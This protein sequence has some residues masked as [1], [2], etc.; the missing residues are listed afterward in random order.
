MKILI[1][2]LIFFINNNSFANYQ[3]PKDF[4]FGV[5]NAPGQ[6][7]DQL[8]DIWMDWADQ[9]QI[10]AFKNEGNPKDKLGF[11]SK[12]EIEI[13][14]A[15]STGITTYRMGIDW[16]RVMPNPETFDQNAIDRYKHIIKLVR[17]KNLKI[18][19]TLM[20]HSIPKW[21]QKMGGW[22]NDEMIK[23]FV[24][25]SQRMIHEFHEDV[26][27]W[28]TF[29]EG[30]VFVTM[31]YTVGIWPPG[32]KSSPLSAA[33][34]GPFVGDSIKA[35]DRMAYAHNEIY[36]W[37]H[38]NYLEIKIGLA[39]NMAYYTGKNW[40]NRVKASFADSSMNW[41]FPEM[42][43]GKMDYF[44]FNYYGAEW[45]KG[46]QIDID[47]EEE[48]SEA[49]R[50]IYPEGLYYILQSIHQKFPK[51]PIIITENGIG[52][53]TDIIRPSYMIEHLMA[54][55]K[56]IDDGI[57]VK[58]YFVWSLTDN[59]EWS[60][61]YC[62]KFGLVAVDRFNNLKRIPRPSHD[63]FKTIAETKTITIPMRDDSWN[64]IQKNV[65]KDRPFCRAPD[66]LTAY[67]KPV[68]R[69]IVPKDWRF[70]L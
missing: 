7:E 54:V 61:G 29:N 48:Y 27:W 44:G 67:D 23:Y 69:K 46:S 41:R 62:P 11:W 66:G 28:A 56:A 18:M 26:E 37:A 4:F 12:P 31:A 6:I 21:A 64:L 32:E 40:F 24:K 45:F 42:I 5:A 50:A 14:L 16:G 13:N 51:V 53:A 30:N 63:L 36:D 2:F 22:K 49:G 70:R 3:F 17:E 33:V 10:V 39:H 19:M 34:I 59:L 43:K 20:H 57:P 9:N 52:D 65:G 47:P 55:K 35:M 1:T 60:D 25:F 15:A 58:G 8:N 38:K 68:K